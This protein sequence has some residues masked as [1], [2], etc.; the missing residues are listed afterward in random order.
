MVTETEAHE[1]V[2]KLL[3]YIEGDDAT[4]REGLEKTPHAR[5]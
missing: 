1:A 2:R 3:A 5:G 4:T